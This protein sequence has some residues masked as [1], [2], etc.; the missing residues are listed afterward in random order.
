[1]HTPNSKLFLQDAW[2]KALEATVSESGRQFHTP[3]LS[4]IEFPPPPDGQETLIPDEEQPFTAKG[5]RSNITK[6]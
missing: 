3:K 6:K 4:A 5:F 2:A 1:M